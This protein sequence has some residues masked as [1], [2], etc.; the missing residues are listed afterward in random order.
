M[1]LVTICLA[2]VIYV[3]S[4]LML[5]ASVARC[6]LNCANERRQQRQSKYHHLQCALCNSIAC[7]TDLFKQLHAA[8]RHIEWL[9]RKG[10]I[11]VIT[12]QL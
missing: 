4:A 2:V 1:R 5:R 3:L 12:V 7:L 8:N 9:Q 10:V 11:I 6:S